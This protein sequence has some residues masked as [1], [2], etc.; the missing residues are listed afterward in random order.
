VADFKLFTGDFKLA[1]DQLVGKAPED[2]K[3]GLFNAAAELL[4]DANNVEPKTPKKEGTLKGSWEIEAS[5]TS[6]DVWELVCGFNEVY[7]SYLHEMAD[8]PMV[9]AHWTEPGSGPKYLESKLTMFGSKYIDI[10]VKSMRGEE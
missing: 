1:F 7:A 4:R 6:P 8:L 9:M 5:Y 2:F 3:R 10:A